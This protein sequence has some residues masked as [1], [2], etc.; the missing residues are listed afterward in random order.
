MLTAVGLLLSQKSLLTFLSNNSF[1]SVRL[2]L[3]AEY[4]YVEPEPQLAYIHSYENPEYATWDDV[5]SVKYIDLLARVIETFQDKKIT[6]LLDIHLLTKYD[7]DGYWYTAPY[8]NV[9][10]SGAYKAITYLA[11]RLCSAAYWNII[12][13]DLKNEMLEA[14]WPANSTDGDVKSDWQQA[15]TTLADAVSDL[16]PQW[17]SFVGGASSPTDYQ[18]FRVSDEYTQ[19]SEHWD[20]G[21]LKNASV[22]PI[23]PSVADKIVYAPH[24]HSH[25]VLPQNYLFTPKTNCSSDADTIEEFDL[26]TTETTT[27]CWD[28]ING[29]KTKSV[30]GCGDSSWACKAYKHLGTAD[31]TTN[32]EKVMAEALGDLPT[33]GEI[34]LVLGSFSGVY[35]EHQ[36]HQKV[37]LDYLIQ[38]SQTI[39]GGYFWALNPDTEF[40]LE[41]TADGEKGVF[42]RTHYGIFQTQSWQE[43]Y[44]DLLKALSLMESTEIPCYGGTD[45]D[46][47]ALGARVAWLSSLTM[48]ITVSTLLAMNAL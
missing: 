40:Y 46:N 45:D 28:Y 25:G 39:Q 43:P 17:L 16:C 14:E 34:P 3:N 32:Y 9:T 35:G 8:V 23:R 22:N 26:T 15:A 48:T 13:I 38:Y 4:V 1:N 33:N 6:V 10:E 31:L 37:V 30:L 11:K 21:N 42:G 18:R 44:E 12:G 5:N 36:P 47:S 7:Q 20:G 19:L 41:D 27:E 2:P 24:A 29:T